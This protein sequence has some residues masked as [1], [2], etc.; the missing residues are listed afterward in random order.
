[1][2]VFTRHRRD[3][4]FHGLNQ[5]P[6]KAWTELELLQ[7]SADGCL[8]CTR[9]K[10][11]SLTVGSSRFSRGTFETS[12]RPFSLRLAPPFTPGPDKN[13]EMIGAGL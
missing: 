8:V 6:I 4:H 3:A 13:N 7:S 9:A 12:G 2:I 10:R 5:S 11:S 1:M